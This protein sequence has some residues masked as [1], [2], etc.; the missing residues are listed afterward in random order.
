MKIIYCSDMSILGSGYRNISVPLCMGLSQ[1]GHEIKTIGLDYHGEEHNF[2]FTIIPCRN[3]RDMSAMI[4]NLQKLW[5]PDILLTSMDIPWHERLLVGL[6]QIKAAPLPYVGIFPLESDPLCFEWANVLLGM[7]GQMCISQFGTEE[8]KKM[9][10]PVEYFPVGIDKDSW[11]LPSADEQKTIREAFGFDED[12]FVILTVADNHERKNLS[13]AFE[14]VSAFKKQSGKKIIYALVTRENLEVGYK[15][16]SLAIRPDI[17]IGSSLRIFER[18]LDFRQLW[19]LYAVADAFLL[20]SKAEG[21]GMPILES[22]IMGVPVV[23]PNHTGMKELLADGRG[24]TVEPSYQFIDTF[25]NGNRYLIDV[26]PAVDA[27][28]IVADTTSSKAEEVA[29]KARLYAE[30]LSW[31]TA[32]VKT[33]KLIRRIHEQAKPQPQNFDATIAKPL[34]ESTDDQ[35]SD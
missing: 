21:L 22:M 16:R 25:G 9:G 10:I 2:P 18:G 19:S 27:L 1:M 3:F 24:F 8:C 6:S 28:T 12:A 34:E 20:T 30:T 15:L 11:R 31:D 35:H 26:Q 4:S 7:T 5:N 14:I 29:M 33:D 13:R 17:E 23:A 32:I